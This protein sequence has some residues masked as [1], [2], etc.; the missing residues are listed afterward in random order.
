MKR[1]IVL[2]VS[3]LACVF[4]AIKADVRVS[5]VG[6]I[7]YS[8]DFDSHTASVGNNDACAIDSVV[9][10]SYV[11]YEGRDRF[12]VTAIGIGAFSDNANIQ[13]LVI[14]EGITRI[15]AAAF[16]GSGLK[17]VTLPESIT[18]IGPYSLE[19][20]LERINLPFS[21]PSDLQVDA[22]AFSSTAREFCKAYLQQ[23]S[24]RNYRYDEYV[25]KWQGF[26]IVPGIYTV[27]VI[28]SLAGITGAGGYLY[29]ENATVSVPDAVYVQGI[30]GWKEVNGKIIS[31]EQSYTFTDMRKDVVIE[32]V[33]MGEY[34]N[35]FY[36]LDPISKEAVVGNNSYTT[37]KS[38]TIPVGVYV[39]SMYFKV[40][41]ISPGA[42]TG[43]K[44]ISS[45][46]LAAS[47]NVPQAFQ[48]TSLTS[49]TIQ[50]S[51]QKIEKA[52]FKNSSLISLTIIGDVET[53]GDSAF[54]ENNLL[55]I[56]FSG[57]VEEIGS[58]AFANNR[59]SSI[60][61]PYNVKY[62][63]ANAFA[64]NRM[65]TAAFA[66]RVKYIGDSAFYSNVLQG[67]NFAGGVEI[68]ESYAFYGNRLSALS[69]TLSLKHI[70][71]YAFADNPVKDIYIEWPSPSYGDLTDDFNATSWDAV[72]YLPRGTE[73][74]Y[75][76]YDAGSKWRGFNFVSS[77][78]YKV[79]VFTTYSQNV[80]VQM[81]GIGEYAY[82]ER[83]TLE[84][85]SV[86]G[87][88]FKKWEN[89][90]EGVTDSIYS[91]TIIQDT[92]LFIA[93]ER[94]SY[95]ITLVDDTLG[96]I[97]QGAGT[98]NLTYETKVPLEAIPYAGNHFV[99][100]IDENGRYLSNDNPFLITVTQDM[101]IQAVFEEGEKGI[102]P[103]PP[104]PPP[105]TP[106]VTTYIVNLLASGGGRVRTSDDRYTYEA[107]SYVSVEAIADD[108]WVFVR[109]ADANG[110]QLAF[111]ESFVFMLKQDVAY[112]AYFERIPVEVLPPPPPIPPDVC[113]SELHLTAGQGGSIIPGEGMSVHQCGSLVVVQ[114]IADDDW[115]FV[116][117]TDANGDSLSGATAFQFVMD[118]DKSIHAYF[119]KIQKLYNVTV[120]AKNAYGTVDGSKLG[121]EYNT[122]VTIKATPV[123]PNHYFVNWIINNIKIVTDSW[124]SFPV[125]EDV[126]AV[127][128]FAKAGS[129]SY[130]ASAIPDNPANG[131]IAVTG[132]EDDDNLFYKN[133]PVKLT[134]EA[135]E[136]YSFVKWTTL[137]GEFISEANPYI[138][139][140][141]KN[142]EFKAVFKPDVFEVSVSSS[143][144]LLGTA[145]GG[146]TYDYN[147]K[148]RLTATPISGYRL[149]GW[150]DGN[151][152]FLSAE[153]PYVFPL[154]KNMTI[155]AVFSNGFKIKLAAAQGGKI[156]SAPD[157][158]YPYGS[159]AKAEAEPDHGYHLDRW[160]SE[161]TNN[162]SVS[163]PCL[164]DVEKDLLLTAR[165]AKNKYKVNVTISGNGRTDVQT[166]YSYETPVKLQAS[167]AVG[168]RFSHWLA[169]N[170]VIT[171][172]EYEFIITKDTAVTAFFIPTEYNVTALSNSMHGKVTGS[173]TYVSGTKVL[174]TATAD[175]GYHF[176][177]WTTAGGNL[178]SNRAS[179][180]FTVRTTPTVY[181]AV[182]EDGLGSESPLS[183][184]EAKAYYTGGTLH[185]VNLEGHTVTATAISGQ[186]V[187][188]LKA[189][190]AG[191][192]HLLP[193]P[194]GIYIL[195]AA[196][197]RD[198]YVTK[199]I[200]R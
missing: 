139:A 133:T 70:G 113:Y 60:D 108:G 200:I 56:T 136:Y 46:T 157:D 31:R 129:D 171:G 150:R 161:Q 165:F 175:P 22:N 183:L 89:A 137:N 130:N 48:N 83:V 155:R 55:S 45:L 132:R 124:Y 172:S 26:D 68:I 180:S 39:D 153:N 57:N 105:P 170:K 140:I 178:V 196:N 23:G 6:G 77:N 190:S 58:Y 36:D 123:S 37:F 131:R 86:P 142:E 95:R 34:E 162:F 47:V 52:A 121:L 111:G 28:S 102:P 173:G 88:V 114:A 54:Y 126:T 29:H 2:L 98:F 177:G 12:P 195:N 191:E 179:Y 184:P 25:R 42:F 127:A 44:K 90:D 79:S 73:T 21:P 17:T 61:F 156:I 187:L 71:A 27:T 141:T 109:W 19:C 62:I 186:K 151:D 107:E 64:G 4:Q 3:C 122:M 72:V 74:A 41:G 188:Q 125:T 149:A 10:P 66:N 110:N 100:W 85:P 198:R 15:E 152:A 16:S 80:L 69:L 38:A 174:F 93:Y 20:P 166:E 11:F 7:V 30:F 192:Q 32:A 146:G 169:G 145:E 159:M 33:Y 59:L 84:A 194:A 24:E 43:N 199:F 197:G 67:V 49:F 75:G 106:T 118:Q 40:T 63:G 13:S 134:A 96:Y 8:F 91:F 92:T 115:H 50:K 97:R 167:A 78:D 160:S 143:N 94:D 119:A 181:I 18:Y 1:E 82:G 135:A 154:K 189:N 164:F 14:S 104:P 81:P 65:Q 35:I 163:N 176:T 101:F 112:K 138:F 182:F 99:E 116:K 128:N 185:L 193:L 9:I 87:W 158:F 168:F 148:V 53:I 120:S 5:S 144:I 76:L 103:P 117:W 147:T 51:I